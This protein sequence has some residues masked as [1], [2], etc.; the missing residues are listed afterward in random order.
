M[1]IHFSQQTNT[2]TPQTVMSKIQEYQIICLLHQG[3]AHIIG[4]KLTGHSSAI[5]FDGSEAADYLSF[6]WPDSKILNWVGL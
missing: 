1:S 3:D 6:R 4:P 2:R 5:A